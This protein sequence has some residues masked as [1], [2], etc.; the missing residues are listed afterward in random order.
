MKE[1]RTWCDHPC[2]SGVFP[3]LSLNTRV[4]IELIVPEAQVTGLGHIMRSLVVSVTLPGL[5]SQSQHC[6]GV[7]RWTYSL[8][9]VDR[10]FL[11]FGKTS[12]NTVFHTSCCQ[13]VRR[14]MVCKLGRVI[15][16]VW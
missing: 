7:C 9:V 10:L 1:S 16:V 4:Y 15:A 12:A 6:L 5:R 2:L 3:A 14:Y 8:A 13:N 11:I